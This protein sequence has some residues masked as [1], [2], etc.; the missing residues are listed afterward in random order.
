V[1]LYATPADPSYHSWTLNKH[2]VFCFVL[3]SLSFRGD[4]FCDHLTFFLTSVRTSLSFL[5][6]QNRNLNFDCSNNM[7]QS[8]VSTFNETDS[9]DLKQSQP[10]WTTRWSRRTIHIV[11]G[12][13]LAIVVLS[14][15][16]GLG[17]GLGLKTSGNDGGS[18]SSSSTQTPTPRSIPPPLPSIPANSEIWKP[19]VNSTWQ[20]VLLEPIKL[21][22]S[23]NSVTPN[24]DV[25]DIDLFN[26][27]KSTIDTLHR[28]GKRVI[29]YFSAGSYEPD[30]PDS[31]QF[32]ASDQGK[33]LDGWAGEYWLNL[34]SANVRSIMA[35]RLDLAAENGCDAVDPDNVDGYVSV[36]K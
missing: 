8:W 1:D 7:S 20:I 17:L 32:T 36:T 18:Q 29:C 26:T 34:N 21:D 19:E 3:N 6:S 10:T 12:V 14:L 2:A 28:L 24:V 15:A 16:L 5:P 33:G 25:F 9:N 13:V 35:K 23:A 30:R 31:G 22:A 27:P 4:F 11:F